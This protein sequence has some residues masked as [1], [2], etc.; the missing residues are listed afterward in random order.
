VDMAL[1]GVLVGN[2]MYGHNAFTRIV[3]VEE[4]IVWLRCGHVESWKAF[5]K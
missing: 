2:R 5:S 1:F 3:A 4:R